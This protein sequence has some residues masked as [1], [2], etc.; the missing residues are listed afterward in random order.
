MRLNLT[1]QVEID[2]GDELLAAQLNASEASGGELDGR[3]S[4]DE[5]AQQPASRDSHGRQP[6]QRSSSDL[7]ALG[8]SA[9]YG[10]A[11]ADD[12]ADDGGGQAA[13]ADAIGGSGPS[14]EAGESQAQ[15]VK[16]EDHDRELEPVKRGGNADESDD[17]SSDDGADDQLAILPEGTETL[18]PAV[19]SCQRS[20][21]INANT[22]SSNFDVRLH[23]RFRSQRSLFLLHIIQNQ[24][25]AAPANQTPICLVRLHSSHVLALVLINNVSHAQL[26][27]FTSPLSPFHCETCLSAGIG[28]P[29]NGCVDWRCK[30][31][32]L[33]GNRV[34][35]SQTAL[36]RQAAAISG[37]F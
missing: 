21:D 5:G 9:V 17:E 23:C 7:D 15:Q 6:V 22:F 36:K 16:D 33:L 1:H 11:G 8:V 14:G 25:N 26:L 28:T 34:M 13:A 30:S 12:K 19:S 4:P 20:N 10:T 2:A 29:A 18:D 27:S 31:C 24:L 35:M 32:C 3:I 37:C